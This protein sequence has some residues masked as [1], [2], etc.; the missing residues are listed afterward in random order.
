M[1]GPC[2]AHLV[3]GVTSER[4]K[5][6]AGEPY[7]PLDPDLSARRTH[8]RELCRALNATR[9]S[10]TDHRRAILHELFGADGETVWMQPPFYC[11]DGENIHLG[12]R[13]FR[14]L[15]CRGKSMPGHSRDS[16]TGTKWRVCADAA[17]IRA[18][19]VKYRAVLA[20]EFRDAP[21]SHP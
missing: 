20:V 14:E 9:E 7:D 8:A 12:E 17:L 15:V 21:S 1:C 16:G 4:S 5:M 18:G 11:D 3:A 2:S 10:E 19:H 6:L 13:V